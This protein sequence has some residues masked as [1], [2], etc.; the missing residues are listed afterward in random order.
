MLLWFRFT[1]VVFIWW[2][3][4]AQAERRVF[5]SWPTTT[6][7]LGFVD[8]EKAIDGQIHVS[9]GGQYALYLGGDLIGEAENG[10]GLVTYDVS[11]KRKANKMGK[12]CLGTL[13]KRDPY[14]W[15][16][17]QKFP[18]SKLTALKEFPDT[19]EVATGV[20]MVSNCAPSKA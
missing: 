19:Q 17:S 3:V 10:A 7:Y 6:N 15:I 12:R 8:F 11:F 18:A 16:H 4:N 13:F 9:V 20:E 2:A 5:S 1:L 14:R